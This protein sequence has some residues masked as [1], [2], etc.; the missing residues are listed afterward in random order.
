MIEKRSKTKTFILTYKLKV[1]EYP[2]IHT[3]QSNVY[4]WGGGGGGG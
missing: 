4:V 1:K 3:T 2:N